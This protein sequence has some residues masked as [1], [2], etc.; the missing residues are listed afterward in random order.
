MNS[1]FSRVNRN[2]LV[3]P[4][5]EYTK[6][7]SL[8][9][10]KLWLEGDCNSHLSFLSF[11]LKSLISIKRKKRKLLSKQLALIFF[12]IFLEKI[13]FLELPIVLYLFSSFL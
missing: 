2:K 8:S 3:I 10:V 7:T 13:Q 12:C 1:I 6:L 9:D 11:H 5:K 4:K